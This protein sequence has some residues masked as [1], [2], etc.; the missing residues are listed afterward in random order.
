MTPHTYRSCDA[1]R[2]DLGTTARIADGLPL[3]KAL[4]NRLAPLMY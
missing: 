3:A 2:P 1:A 4:V